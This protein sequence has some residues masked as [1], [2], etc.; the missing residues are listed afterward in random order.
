MLFRSAPSE[1]ASCV[2]TLVVENLLP[3]TLRVVDGFRANTRLLPELLVSQFENTFDLPTLGTS[4]LEAL[5]PVLHLQPSPPTPRVSQPPL[6]SWNRIL[7]TASNF[8]FPY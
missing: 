6:P 1:V 3:E 7:L 8:C 2:S 4:L 5:C